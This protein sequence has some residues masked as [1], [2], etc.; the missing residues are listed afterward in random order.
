M[1]LEKKY[2]WIAGGFFVLLVLA[3]LLGTGVINLTKTT[4]KTEL[5]VW[6]FDDRDTWDKIAVTYHTDNPTI[7]ITYRA[8]NP[9]TYE[10]ELLNGLATGNGPDLFMVKNSWLARHGDKMAPAPQTIATATTVEA[11]FPAVVAQELTAAGTAYAL[12]L[13]MDSYVLV[14]NK[15]L[16]DRAGILFPPKNW[17][18]FQDIVKKINANSPAGGV[19][20]IGGSDATIKGATDILG[21]LMMQSGAPM[22]DT[23]GL[24][25]FKGGEDALAFYTKFANPQS[26]YYAWDNKPPH[27]FT[28]FGK[29]TLPMMFATYRDIAFLR[30]IIPTLRIGIAPMPQAPQAPVNLAS[31]T[32]LSVWVGSKHPAVA[33]QFIS[34]LTTNPESARAYATK[35]NVPPAL[36]ALIAQLENDP[37]V[38]VFVRQS[39]TAR[40]W[41]RVNEET[42][43]RAFSAMIESVTSGSLTPRAALQKTEDALNN[44]RPLSL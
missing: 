43:S 38:G 1:P 42:T 37:N 33:W 23:K 26:D 27:M 40:P 22:I 16:F 11:D 28:R 17:L 41:Y 8:L 12:P 18:E 36:R 9:E 2:L 4:A 14:Y 31:Y 24:A 3:V 34:D 21:L 29:G 5:T 13:Y 6:G 44:K 7:T 20:A 10:T 25:N 39:L 30:R 32:A 35:Q 15:D 19:A